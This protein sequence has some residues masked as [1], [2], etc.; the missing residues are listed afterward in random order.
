MNGLYRLQVLVDL[1]DRLS[2]P[3]TGVLGK[4]EQFEMKTV[5]VDRAMQT[6]AAGQQAVLGP[7]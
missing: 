7:V 6:M 4:L 5:V 1:V 2:G 3:I